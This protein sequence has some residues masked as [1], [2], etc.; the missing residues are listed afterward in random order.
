MEGN[1]LSI[2]LKCNKGYLFSNLLTRSQT[3][4]EITYGNIYLLKDNFFTIE[5]LHFK[6]EWE[7]LC[8]ANLTQPFLMKCS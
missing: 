3:Y 1:L 5:G 2:C 7:E 6:D 8:D 4:D